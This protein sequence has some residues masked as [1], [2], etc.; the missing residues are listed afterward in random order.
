MTEV[1]ECGMLADK[2]CSGLACSP[3]A[4]CHTDTNSLSLTEK[5]APQLASIKIKSRIASLSLEK[6]LTRASVDIKTCTVG[7][8]KFVRFIPFEHYGQVLHQGVVPQAE[9]VLYASAPET[10]ITYCAVVKVPTDFPKDYTE[11]LKRSS[12]A[13]LSWA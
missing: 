13:L 1:P 7:G 10:G 11:L 5:Y 2:D 12:Q 4:I 9:F 3:D 6:M 8:I